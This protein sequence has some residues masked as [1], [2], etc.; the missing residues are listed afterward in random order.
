M[1]DQHLPQ[2]DDEVVEEIRPP[3]RQLVHPCGSAL[4]GRL[5]YCP[6]CLQLLAAG[7][8]PRRGLHYVVFQW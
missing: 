3:L 2:E 5:I 4:Y 7:E 8:Q 6:E 1:N